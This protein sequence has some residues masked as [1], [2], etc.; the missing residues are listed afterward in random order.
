MSKLGYSAVLSNDSIT[1]TIDGEAFTVEE[2]AENFRPLWDAIGRRED[3][4]T[5]RTLVSVNKAI[6][7]LV[8]GA[9]TF[10]DKG[11]VFYRG[12]PAPDHAVRT[13]LKAL[14][15]DQD[16]RPLCRFFDKAF[17][18]PQEGMVHELF[19]YF[20]HQGIKI[21]PD[22]DI[23]ALK[24][25]RTTYF[26]H[27]SGTISYKPGSVVQMDRAACDTNRGRDCSSG[28]HFCGPGYVN[29]FGGHESRVVFVKINPADVTSI[30]NYSGYS[31]A[32]CC[33]MHVIGESTH[34][35]G[36]GQFSLWQSEIDACLTR[37][38]AD[39]VDTTPSP[40]KP[41]AAKTVAPKTDEEPVLVH[42]RHRLA[43]SHLRETV[44]K[45]GQRGVMREYGVPRST[46]QNF[47]KRHAGHVEPAPPAR[48]EKPKTSVPSVPRQVSPK[49]AAEVKP[50]Q[51]AGLAQPAVTR[52]LSSA[53]KA[54]SKKAAE[55]TGTASS[56]VKDRTQ[57]PAMK[58]G[59]SFTHAG[60]TYSGAFI[61][62]GIERAGQRG[63]S[64]ETG[65]PRTTLQKWM[66]IIAAAG[67]PPS[68]HKVAAVTPAPSKRPLA[69]PA[70]PSKNRPSKGGKTP[71]KTFTSRGA[72]FTA[73]HIKERVTAVG[74][75]AAAREMDV[76]RTTIQKWLKEIG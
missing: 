37:L 55:E 8:E 27:H 1:V 43:L 70:T 3:V 46:L 69:E 64:A 30:P 50:T 74:Q 15:D 7:K 65:I 25:V 56:G 26:D 58:G 2:S 73:S 28:L 5:V 59:V 24:I 29:Q 53:E 22:G 14:D 60:K 66:K 51:G 48:I 34:P 32:R 19:D 20:R 75:R 47:L 44:G 76:P 9:F 40:V 21:T 71:E 35:R 52:K 45:I 18:N 54:M 4:E 36:A 41:K 38:Y 42:G 11:A 13:L 17:S 72:T 6:T 49:A 57:A 23:L 16:V 61:A 67:Q 63:F 33:R 10:N 68:Q 31:K 12:K 39:H 62:K